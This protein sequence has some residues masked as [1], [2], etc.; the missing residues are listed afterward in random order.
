MKNRRRKL[1]WKH[2]N[3]TCFS[4]IMKNKCLCVF[5]YYLSVRLTTAF[6]HGYSIFEGM[7]LPDLNANSVLARQKDFTLTTGISTG[8][9]FKTKYIRIDT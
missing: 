3:K 2:V 1:Q 5:L 6:V 4:Q 8:D 9:V 7:P